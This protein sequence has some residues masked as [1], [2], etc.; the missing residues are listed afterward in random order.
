MTNRKVRIESEVDASGAKQGFEEIKHDAGSM[1]DAVKRAGKHA[2]DG[3]D[4][5]IT[6]G[7]A[8][9]GKA[10][11]AANRSL[12]SSIK[13]QTTAF[14]RELA[15]TASGAARGSAAYFR[16]YAGCEGLT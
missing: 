10:V 7:A 5:G 14:Q 13:R 1:A 15:E 9:S 6:Q 3:M 8:K 4:S 12:L 16:E 2:G 11:A